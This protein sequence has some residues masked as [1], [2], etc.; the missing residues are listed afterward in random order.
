MESRRE[1]LESE[2]AVGKVF[3]CGTGREVSINELANLMIRVSGRSLEILHMEG[4]PGDI[5]RSCANMEGLGKCL[6][7]SRK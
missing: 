1:V 2:D 4:R 6:D 3:N 7:S 5:K